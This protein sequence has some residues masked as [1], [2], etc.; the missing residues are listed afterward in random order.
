MERSVTEAP[1][2][3]MLRY[4]VLQEQT[5]PLTRTTVSWRP[6]T[7]QEVNHLISPLAIT[8]ISDLTSA[9]PMATVTVCSRRLEQQRPGAVVPRLVD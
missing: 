5:L 7:L 2:A 6:R 4:L 3:W 1:A 9:I 8:D